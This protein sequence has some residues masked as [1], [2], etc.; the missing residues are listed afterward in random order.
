MRH[1]QDGNAASRG[2]ETKAR[3]Q[4]LEVWIRF[5]RNRL[6]VLGLA[7]FLVILFMALFAD[8][9]VPYEKAIEQDV[10]GSLQPP[11][12]E[13]IFG[14]DEFGRDIFARIV[15]GSRFSISIGFLTTVVS[16]IIGC[17][18]GAMAAFLGKAMDNFVF[19]LINVVISIPLMVLAILMI[20]I[21]GMGLQNLVL[22]LSVGLWPGYAKLA[23][24][25]I[26]S[27]KRVDYVESARA[28]GLSDWQIIL[29]HILPN[30]MGPLI[31][32]AA[33]SLAGCIIA[34]SGLSFIG[35]GIQPP[36]P[37]WGG[38]VSAGQEFLR[39][40][41]HIVFISGVFILVSALSINL[42]GDGVRDAL[43]PKMKR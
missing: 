41:P 39:N 22:A 9:I 20:T 8:L 4:L 13:H 42:I 6:A 10:P 35:L 23:R 34:A 29:R 21:T 32:N 16:F 37:E 31:V 27:I 15:H 25:Q 38:M 5:R 11:S 12:L 18:I 36:D 1:T 30:V 40:A 14:T 26:L 33:M 3:S 43:D 28:I 24:A 17:A 7:I 2:D 19:V